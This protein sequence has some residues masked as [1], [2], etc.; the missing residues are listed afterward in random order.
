MSEK[1][2]SVLLSQRLQLLANLPPVAWQNGITFTPPPKDE[3]WLAEYDMPSDTSE[4]SISLNGS[5]VK[6]GI[7]QIN[8]FTPIGQ[9]RFKQYDFSEPL[10]DLYRAY[11]QDGLVIDKCVVKAS[12]NN[13]TFLMTPMEIHYTYIW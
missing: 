2:A 3:S 9:G 5:R 11:K 12:K 7:Y 6:K 8:I 4:I 1:Q 13:D 10:T